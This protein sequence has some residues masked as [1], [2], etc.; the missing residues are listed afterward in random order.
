MS[1]LKIDAPRRYMK[2]GYAFANK[3]SVPGAL[4]VRL[5][6]DSDWRRIMAVVRAAD[7]VAA[8]GACTCPQCSAVRDLR[9][10]LSRKRD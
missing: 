8:K 3:D 9:A 1:K 7:G 10:H 6:D 4:A 5:V 2:G